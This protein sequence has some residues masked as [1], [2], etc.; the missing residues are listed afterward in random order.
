[1]HLLPAKKRKMRDG[2]DP[3]QN[4]V[5]RL[6]QAAEARGAMRTELT[7]LSTRA[8]PTACHI[9]NSHPGR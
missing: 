9:Q 7:I 8:G 4:V 3:V 6:A 2:T 1:M 5:D